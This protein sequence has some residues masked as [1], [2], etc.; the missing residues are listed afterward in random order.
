MTTVIL[1][2]LVFAFGFC[3]GGLSQLKDLDKLNE[4]WYQTASKNNRDWAEYCETLIDEIKTLK[5]SD[6]NAR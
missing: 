4:Q 1:I 3:F 5:G 2:M 6:N